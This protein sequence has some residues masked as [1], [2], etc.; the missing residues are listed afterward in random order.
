MDTPQAEEAAYDYQVR[1][2]ILTGTHALTLLHLSALI[3][4][5]LMAWLPCASLAHA[6]DAD[7]GQV[8]QQSQIQ[9]F[10]TAMEGPWQ[11]RAV[12][13]PAGP[14]PY[15]INF[16]RTGAN[17]VTGAADPGAA[18]H[19]WLFSAQEKSLRLRFLTTF[20]GNTNPLFLTASTR[21][22]NSFVFNAEQRDDLTVRVTPGREVTDIDVFL[23]GDAH[24][25]IKLRRAV[26]SAR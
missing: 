9:G 13:T 12:V 6:G 24:V 23:R 20:G 2:T 11:G 21:A 16:Q 8:L 3:T 15:D 5:L 18:I 17:T 10:L 4:Q 7:N 14:L 25:Q 22:G 26:S 19:H 1:I